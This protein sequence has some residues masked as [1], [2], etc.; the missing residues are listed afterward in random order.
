MH[1][2]CLSLA[3]VQRRAAL[4]TSHVKR[5]D[6]WSMTIFKMSKTLATIA[7]VGSR[8]VVA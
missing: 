5:W 8:K 2:Y 4:A 6:T 3:N 1:S 7:G